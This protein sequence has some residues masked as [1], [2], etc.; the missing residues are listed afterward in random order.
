[1]RNCRA[2]LLVSLLSSV[3]SIA[4]QAPFSASDR[5]LGVFLSQGA[6]RLVATN[7]TTS[8][9]LGEL[10]LTTGSGLPGAALRAVSGQTLSLATGGAEALRVFSDGRVAIGA[11]YN[12]GRLS[13][14]DYADGGSALYLL[15][16]TS[17]EASTSQ[18]EYGMT[19]VERQDIAAGATNSG[20]INGAQIES[21]NFGPGTAAMIMGG[22]FRAGNYT[23]TSGTVTRT[24]G[25]HVEVLAGTGTVT[26]GR[27]VFIDDV[28]ATTGYGI[29]QA[30]TNDKNYFAGETFFQGPV[31]GTNIRAT[32]QD[33]AEWVPSREDL[34]PG[35]VVVLDTAIGNAVMPSS[36]AYDTTVAGVVSAQ[37][38]ITL[39][40]ESEGQEQI[41]T[42]GRV[43]VF[44]DATAAPIEAG[45]LLVTSSVPGMAMKSIPID[46]G[47]VAIHRPG[48]I[49][50]KALGPLAGGRGEILV[51]LSMQ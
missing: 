28:Q 22:R 16:Q 36:R 12:L 33:I 13:V 23:N 5:R 35:T 47:G 19:I 9:D 44:V 38:G 15:Q 45:D 18:T 10:W 14:L 49:I 24:H 40:V 27:G 32:Y 7:A 51:L 30:G 1:M 41:A 39:G 29:Y 34:A 37:P 25:L 11:P 20:A 31:T 17:V 48:T 4:A 46:V 6:P 43:K 2:V 21:W 26:E 50:G 8:G 42:T 3:V